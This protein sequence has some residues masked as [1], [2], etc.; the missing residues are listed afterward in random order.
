M[1]WMFNVEIWASL[2]TLTLLEVVL[3]IDNLVFLT[4]AA[5]GLPPEKRVF[6]QRL[7][8]I[9]ALVMRI[10]FL[11]MVVW[12]AGLSEPVFEISGHAVSWRDIVLIAGGL[13]LIYKGT[14]EIHQEVEGEPEAT[15]IVAKTT[16]FAAITQIMILDLVFSL[17]SIITAIGLTDVLPVM[18]AAITIAIVVMMFAAKPV[19]EFIEKHPTTKMLA[20][21][22][23]LLIGSALIVD[24]FHIHIPREYIYFAI[25]FSL[26]VEALN[27]LVGRKKKG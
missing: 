4:V 18:I 1:E 2:A 24:G 12:I 11:S 19:G 14:Q 8:L 6:V 20:L 27:L 9:G 25:A 3:G 17:D 7:G 10:L 13:F 26:T 16:M 23:L 21:S 22:F 5:N 15:G